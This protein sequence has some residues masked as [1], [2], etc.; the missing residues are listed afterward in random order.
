MQ[1]R[2]H[3]TVPKTVFK[4][5]VQGKQ[6]TL[7]SEEIFKAKRI[8]VFA[9]PGAFTPTCST[10]HL[11]RYEEL[12]PVFLKHGIDAIYCLSVNDFYVME[13]WAREHRL[14]HVKMLPDGNGDFTRDM[15]MLVDKRD[16]GLGERSWRYSMLVEDGRIQKMYIEPE[17]PGDPYGVSDA[18]TMLRHIAPKAELP[19]KAFIFTRDGCPYCREAKELL[20]ENGFSFKEMS[21][22]AQGMSGSV[23]ET[24]TGRTTTPQV[25]V[26]GRHLG[27]L[28]ALRQFLLE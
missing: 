7:S 28:D 4:T 3:E 16:A 1:D 21:V 15:G 20:A 10:A 27:G 5:R 24:L 17:E 25:Y 2:T 14:Q 13:A 19:R 9:L 8:V 26:E 12:G 23:F 18:D 11:P 22:G 6:R